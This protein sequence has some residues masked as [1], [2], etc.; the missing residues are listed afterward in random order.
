MFAEKN[1]FV[2]K[3]M[4]VEKNIFAEK[5]MFVEKNMFA[6]KNLF[7]E[8]RTI[9]QKTQKLATYDVKR[10]SSEAFH[11]ILCKKSIGRS[12]KLRYSMYV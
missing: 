7:V 5:N 2:E 6:E 3:N 12:H 4:V 9:L 10:V 11:V 1:M 8:D